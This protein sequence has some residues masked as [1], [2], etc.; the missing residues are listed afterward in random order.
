METIIAQIGDFGMARL[1]GEEHIEDETISSPVP[2]A[3]AAVGPPAKPRQV[4]TANVAT[5]SYRYDS[6]CI[7]YCLL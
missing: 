7:T 4:Y 5:P 1:H 3:A 6:S 2:E